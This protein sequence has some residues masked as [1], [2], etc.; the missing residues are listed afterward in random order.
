MAHQRRGA[1]AALTLSL[2]LVATTTLACQHER[3]PATPPPPPAGAS[4]TPITHRPPNIILVTTDDQN[5]DELRWMPRTRRELAGHGL[6][7]THAL[8]PDPLCCPARAEIMTGQ[9]GQNNGVSSNLGLHGGF[10]ALREKQ[11]TLASWLRGV[12]YRTALVGKYLNGYTGRDGRQHGWTRWNPAVGDIYS[13]VHTE[14]YRD[15]HPRTF[16][17]NVTPVVGHFAQQYV[18]EFS[19]TGKPFF[20]WASFLPPHQR[21]RHPGGA[22]LLPLPTARHRHDLEHV[23]ATS[24]SKPSFDTTQG[25][26]PQPWRTR[27]STTR[28]EVQSLFTRRLQSLQDVDVAV[29]RLLATLRRTHELGRTYVFFASDNGVLLGEHRLM[30]KDVLFQEALRVPL[31]V[32][33]PGAHRERTSR[34]PVTLAD[35]APTIVSLAGAT[36]GRRMD[37]R[38]FDAVLHGHRVRWRDTQLIQTGRHSSPGDRAAWAFRGVMTSR[39]TYMR[40]VADGAPFLYDRRVDPFETTDV[41]AQPRYRHILA[42]LSHR[43]DVLIHCAGATCNRRFGPVPPPRG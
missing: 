13:Y 21:R 35:L 1:L 5:V 16:N 10:S 14:L 30:G 26:Q 37:G 28:T 18:R 43:T 27:P 25:P 39:Y 29:A 6:V 3:P 19:A 15:G 4:T 22:A 34:I 33:V 23:P 31:V 11:N 36:P 38:S 40:R 8:S 24:L 42:A 20:I 2:A 17:R 9:L 12:G 7:F 32:R 41:A